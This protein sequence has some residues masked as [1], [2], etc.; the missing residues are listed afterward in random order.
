VGN[1]FFRKGGAVAVRAFERLRQDHDL[2]L[3]VVS[4]M[5]ED[6]YVVPTP[7]GAGAVWRRRLQQDGVEHLEDLSFPEVRRLLATADVLLL[8]TYDD[9][10]GFSVVEAMATGVASVAPAIRALPEIVEHGETGLLF[11]VPTT[12]TR[13]LAAGPDIEGRLVAATIR[14]L[15]ELLEDPERMRAMGAKAREVYE[16]RFHPNR[17]ARDLEAVYGAALDGPAGTLRNAALQ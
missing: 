10:F 2:K 15:S 16:R 14:S 4:R 13:R 8:P 12:P 3:T 7:P 5:L 1:E 6:N 17:L 9:S 11:P